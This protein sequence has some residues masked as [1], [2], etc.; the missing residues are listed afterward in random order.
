MKPK[1]V[2][3]RTA[4]KYVGLISLATHGWLGMAHHARAARPRGYGVDPDLRNRS[5][6]WTKTLNSSQ[7]EAL[8]TLCDIVL[9]DAPP[10]PS[11]RA[12]KVDDFL[13]E[14]LSAPYPQMQADRLL[15]LNG[16]ERMD[17]MM[18]SELGVPFAKAELTH[19]I[20]AFDRVCRSED[21]VGFARRLIELICDGYYPTRAG[22]AAIGYVGN[23]PLLRFPGAPPSI[24]RHL[25]EQFK[26]LPPFP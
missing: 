23:I 1:S 4:L 9:P 12:I 17:T 24:A 19:Q 21:D 13:D 26:A 16:L 18:L 6:T 20:A 10:H 15:V 25:E 14:W 2:T 5:V 8:A 7:L 3:R 22:H 11:A